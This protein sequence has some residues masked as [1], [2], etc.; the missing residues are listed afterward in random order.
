[1]QYGLSSSYDVVARLSNGR[2]DR[3]Y[4]KLDKAIDWPTF[5]VS[6][7]YQSGYT[8]WDYEY[9]NHNGANIVFTFYFD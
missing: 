2:C 5:N 1:M 9:C 3:V 7:I 4:I 8:T 6:D